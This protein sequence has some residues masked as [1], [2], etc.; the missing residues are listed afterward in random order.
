M[1][2]SPG[3]A[4]DPLRIAD[5]REFRQALRQLLTHKDLTFEEIDRKTNAS[6]SKRLSKTT[7]HSKLK[8]DQLPEWEF[9]ENLV[10]AC[11]E[12]ADKV[13]DW[14]TAWT[15]VRDGSA[16]VNPDAPPS[17][18]PV[19]KQLRARREPL[20]ALSSRLGKHKRG[21][22]ACTAVLALV[23]GGVAAWDYH[24]RDQHCGTS[25][26]DL[27]TGSDGE[28]TGIT[29]GSDGSDIFGRALAPV[30]TAIG[31]E[32]SNVT[33]SDNYVT[34]AF[35]APMTVKDTSKD[36]AIGQY[37]AEI[38]GA[39][40]AVEQQNRQ[41]SFPKIRLVL[42]NMGDGE[43]QWKD[44][45][46]RLKAAKSTSRPVA[47]AGMGLSRQE[48]VDAAR[49]L[50][51]ADI[52]MVADLITA[53]GFDTTGTVDGK[54]PINGLVRITLTD[55]TQLTVLGKEL[56]GTQRSA[57]LV[58]TSV[59]P[60]GTTDYYTESIYHGFQTVDGLRQHLDPG[61]DFSFDPRS[62]PAAILPTIGQNICSTGTS[63]DTVYFA[64][65]EKY[66][67]DFLTALGRRSC[68]RQHIT[69]VT[70]S[71]AAALDPKTR[72]LHDKD[73]PLTVLYA[74]FPSSAQL[75]SASRPDHSL[76]NAYTQ[77]FTATHHGRQFPPADATHGYWAVLAYDA[78]TTAATAIHNAAS[79]TGPTPNSYAVRDQL[80]AL[81][82]KAIPAATGR[83]G[84]DTTG[85]RTTT[86]TTI[87]R[88]NTP[89]T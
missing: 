16:P 76:Y 88:I 64:A 19:N 29:D 60:D 6:G 84:I 57:A 58:R 46:D 63:I 56:P 8:N 82:D 66:L 86:P 24:Q 22:I 28:C 39:Y 36:L 2:P 34:V 71:D 47:V 48:S 12:P 33:R 37:V 55:S 14:H 30:L 43:A 4:P 50:S 5:Q 53:D 49:S 17:S 40:T 31:A 83:F 20:R 10:T 80:Y 77:A 15:A 38:E 85:N 9:V 18:T 7:V 81:P 25:N 59:T 51:T 75:S 41:N 54:G 69:V 27:V 65:R 13:A 1:A 78:I 3:A 42:A 11:D 74:T 45:V 52:P 87:H 44:S 26:P 68:H 61:A 73:A 72:A 70:G 67:P 23:L 62:G 89:T 35:L 32:N 21:L 79:P